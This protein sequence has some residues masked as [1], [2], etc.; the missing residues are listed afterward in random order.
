M[1]AG[2][3]PAESCTA[4]MSVWGDGRPVF[5]GAEGFVT[6]SFFSGIMPVLWLCLDFEMNMNVC[7]V[8]EVRHILSGVDNIL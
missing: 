7:P 1:E 3:S 2:G 8:L 6:S 5:D 4:H